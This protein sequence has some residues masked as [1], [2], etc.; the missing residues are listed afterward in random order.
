MGTLGSGYLSD[1]SKLEVKVD[2]EL[3]NVQKS[4]RPIKIFYSIPVTST[5]VPDEC[6]SLQQHLSRLVFSSHCSAFCRI[7]FKNLHLLKL[8]KYYILHFVCISLLKVR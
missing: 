7:R 4:C 8:F 1:L 5:R 6:D 3:V 2:D